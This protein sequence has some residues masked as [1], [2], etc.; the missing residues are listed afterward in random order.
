MGVFGADIFDESV[1]CDD[2]V[3]GAA[4]DDDTIAGD[5]DPLGFDEETESFVDSVL[6]G[7]DTWFVLSTLEGGIHG[8]SFFEGCRSS[9]SDPVLLRIRD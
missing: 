9:G 8:E 7:A 4:D 3:G 6:D 2:D 1:R 5:F